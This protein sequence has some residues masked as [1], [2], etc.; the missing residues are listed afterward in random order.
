M[1]II[2]SVVARETIILAEYSSARGNFDQVAKRILEKIPA[3]PDSKAVYVYERHVFHYMVSNGITFMCMADE[4]FGRR[5]PFAFLEDLQKRFHSTYGEHAKMAHSYSLNS[6]MSKIMKSLMEKYS[7]TTEVDKIN[8]IKNEIDETKN[9]MVANIEK[10]LERGERIELLV[11]KTED[12]NRNALQFKKSST[13][14]KRA[15][16]FKNVK[17]MAAI[18]ITVLIII[19]IIVLASCGG[20]TFSKCRSS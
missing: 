9:V 13:A 4:S 19:F 7:S 18:I 12:L 1:P 10:V 15:M 2:Y 8:K 11:D 5:V 14:L 3:T 17:L 6:D 16:W 20:F